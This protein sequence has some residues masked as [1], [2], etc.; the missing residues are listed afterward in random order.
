MDKIFKV[1]LKFWGSVGYLY[2]S[3]LLKNNYDKLNTKEKQ[4]LI[5][6]L[7]ICYDN[8]DK[9]DSDEIEVDPK[10]I[11]RYI[12]TGDEFA[13]L[14]EVIANHISEYFMSKIF[15]EHISISNDKDWFVKFTDISRIGQITED[16]WM[17]FTKNNNFIN[18]TF[19]SNV[20]IINGKDLKYIDTL[21]VCDTDEVIINSD[22]LLDNKN[23]IKFMT[24]E[25]FLKTL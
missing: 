9:L 5:K 12:E 17:S 6:L 13:D 1:L 8:I 10:Y 21:G 14:M 3:Q 23:R 4:D 11:N 19:G 15:N 16:R 24:T 7:N 18:D 20:I 25:Q 22:V 2:Y